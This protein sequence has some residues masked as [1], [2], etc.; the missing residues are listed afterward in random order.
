MPPP[1]TKEKRGL[2]Q[3]FE[4]F[5]NA[6]TGFEAKTKRL[7]EL[8][9]RL[10]KNN[11]AALRKIHAEHQVLLQEVA[12]NHDTSLT[13]LK[14]K[15]N[16]LFVG[17]RLDSIT[18]GNTTQFQGLQSLLDEK[19]AS[20]KD[21]DDGTTPTNEELLALIMPLVP[22]APDI[23]ELKKIVK[24]HLA[25][26]ARLKLKFARF[27]RSSGQGRVLAGP[28]AN[29]VLVHVVSDQCG[30]GN[31]RFVMPMAR[32]VLKFEMSQHPFNLYEDT[33]AETHGFTVGDRFI[34]LSADAPAPK[35]G[36]SA[37]IYYVK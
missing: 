14:E 17:K 20:V 33:N 26:F 36:Q 16:Q 28:N 8:V 37:A 3:I 15:T 12:K 24:D 27:D 23:T 13:E 22:Q 21:G 18:E 6:N 1:A 19:I 5:D 9:V 7:L 2:S 35:L 11:E 34:D 31:R 32:K 25:E 30:D 29:A 4:E 10:V